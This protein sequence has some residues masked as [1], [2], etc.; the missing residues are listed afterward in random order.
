M[1][2][3][4]TSSMEAQASTQ[5]EADKLL[6]AVRR[7]VH[8]AETWQRSLRQSLAHER[9]RTRM[10]QA[11]LEDQPILEK[12]VRDFHQMLADAEARGREQ[13]L[14]REAATFQVEAA[15]TKLREELV[16]A[17]EERDAALAHNRRQR[18]ELET[19]ESSTVTLRRQ[20]QLHEKEQESLRQSFILGSSTSTRLEAE[21]AT[22][23]AEKAELTS[24]RHNAAQEADLRYKDLRDK[25]K[26]SMHGAEHDHTSQSLLKDL[27]EAVSGQRD[28]AL[29][30]V[31]AE[32]ERWQ[33]RLDELSGA[34]QLR[35][36]RLEEEST[37][38]AT[39][40]RSALAVAE[41]ARG[42]VEDRL[43]KAEADNAAFGERL[44][45]VNLELWEERSSVSTL[46]SQLQ[47]LESSSEA[48]QEELQRERRCI[49]HVRSELETTTQEMEGLRLR[50]KVKAE[51]LQTTEVELQ[52]T[53]RRL[54]A[55]QSK[56]DQE[57]QDV[58]SLRQSLES[59]ETKCLELERATGSAE[60]TSFLLKEV[61]KQLQA[62][63]VTKATLLQS[64]ETEKME[65]QRL[66]L[67]VKRL[68][69][70]RESAST[71]EAGLRESE[72]S[73]QTQLTAAQR[74]SAALVRSLEQER[75]S[76]PQFGGM[77]LSLEPIV[78][79]HRP[80]RLTSQEP[81]RIEPATEMVNLADKDV[82]GQ[83][84][85]SK[86]DCGLLTQASQGGATAGAN[87]DKDVLTRA[88]ASLRTA[89]ANVPFSPC[90]TASTSFGAQ[91]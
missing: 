80:A 34:A 48:A 53:A 16:L 57:N 7:R 24:Q 77:Q 12:Q 51:Q 22:L 54:T 43:H 72:R 23:R 62:A 35:V 47:L 41:A 32:E 28:D 14:R 15:Q 89:S 69:R 13:A 83:L 58:H 20:L 61:K 18:L 8:D 36:E 67:E 2:A 56:T 21:V 76:K 88:S 45:Q 30:L 26:T 10:L 63:D 19:A 37:R 52:E 44:Q 65:V 74:E 64:L 42:A 71:R 40:Q 81:N 9:A 70:E 39:K 5:A 59:M 27:L 82:I 49:V 31:E 73:L 86:A 33:G 66:L 91:S 4:T 29:K 25:F 79:E 55:L 11:R 17:R 1:V 85:V 84:G 38:M 90:T 46:R 78:Q 3:P 68:S 60:E 50:V 6:D 75:A 87:N